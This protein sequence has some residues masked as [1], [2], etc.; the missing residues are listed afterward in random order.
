MNGWLLDTNVISLAMK[1]APDPRAVAWL[2]SKPDA[3]LYVSAFTFAEIAKGIAKLEAEGDT[4]WRRL[5]TISAAIRARYGERVLPIDDR[6]LARWGRIAGQAAAKKITLSGIDLVVG[7]TASVHGLAVA[8]RN[9][10]HF[11]EIV[12]VSV[13]DPWAA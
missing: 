9:V 1:R 8:T 6:V 11:P 3:D 7:A 10:R 5:A 13:V 2:N 12:G 4:D